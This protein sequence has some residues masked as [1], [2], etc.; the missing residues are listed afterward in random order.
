MAF[1]LFR[2]PDC[3]LK[4]PQIVE[5]VKDTDDIDTVGDGLL[6]EILYNVVRIGLVAENV[7]AAEKHLQFGFLEAFA[8]LAQTDPRIFLQETKGRVKCSSAPAL[9]GMI[10][11]LI[12]LVDDRKHLVCR[13]TG[14]DQ[15]L[16]RVTQDSLS[17]FNRFF[18]CHDSYPFM[19]FYTS[20]GSCPPRADSPCS[21]IYRGVGCR[22]AVNFVRE[23]KP[24]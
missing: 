18:L 19:K 5:A 15:G 1:F 12:H 8:Q 4:V 23:Y 17:Y 20:C 11:Y 16:M 9:Y 6:N 22:P 21:C 3:R 2:S 24:P 10:A 14:C 13:H 7:L